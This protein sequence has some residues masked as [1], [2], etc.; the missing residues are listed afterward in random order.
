MKYEKP[1][2]ELVNFVSLKRLAYIEEQ[3]DSSGSTNIL[4]GEES[5]KPRPG[6]KTQ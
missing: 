3:S 4:S 1:E 2:V 5:V 6:G